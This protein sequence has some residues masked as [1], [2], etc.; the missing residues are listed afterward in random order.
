MASLGMVGSDF[1]RTCHNMFNVD[2]ALFDHCR[3]SDFGREP[4]GEPKFD[5]GLLSLSLGHA[6]DDA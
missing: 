3:V 4:I 1:R 5:V 6:V 2:H